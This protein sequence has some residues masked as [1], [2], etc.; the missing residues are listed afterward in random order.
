MNSNIKTYLLDISS[1]NDESF[2]KLLKNVK[3]Y[4]KDKI[5]SLTLK[6]SKYL[7]LAVEL[8][9][10]KACLDFNLD[11]E[12]IE[13][14]FNENG[15]PYFKNSKYFFN[16]AHSGNYAIC[17]ISDVEIGIDI[18]QIK[19]FKEK[20]SKHCFTKKEQ[21][22]IEL[23]K[24]K[25]DMFYRLWTLKESYTK[26]V[27]KGLNIAFN[28]LELS[29]EDSDI[30]VNNDKNY[31]FYETKYDNYRIAWCLKLPYI[32]KKKYISDITLISL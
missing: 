7:S 29:G 32:D 25:E 12:N 15:K 13:I 11:Y 24:D 18:E 31:Q 22:Y 19:E 16:T 10:K 6:S 20:V 21:K 8:L 9:I 26:C 2:E 3:Q 14:C 17:V 27:G 28:T 1:I 23:S 5:A 30:F 4:R